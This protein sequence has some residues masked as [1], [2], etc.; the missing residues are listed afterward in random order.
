MVDYGLKDKVVIITGANNPQGIGATTALSFA[1]N[2]AKIVIVYKKIA[3]NYDE[4]KTLKNG[5]DRYY[6][7]NS[8][9][10]QTVETKLRELNA[11]YITLE[12]DISDKIQVGEIFNSAIKQFGKIDILVNNAAVDD[13]TG[14]DTIENITSEIIDS[15]FSVNVRGSMLMMKEFIKNNKN[16]GRI[17]NLSTDSSQ[18]F[19]GQ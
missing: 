14:K 1:R 13:E 5:F 10:T 9:N 19:A 7:L 11:Q 12:K 6:K 17:I 15:I 4:S 3:Y 18:V 8:E 16:N 2:K